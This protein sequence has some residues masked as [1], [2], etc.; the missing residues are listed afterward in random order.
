M[1]SLVNVK[2]SVSHSGQPI[3]AS[4]TVATPWTTSTSRASMERSSSICS[5]PCR[6]S[7]EIISATLDSSMASAYGCGMTQL[8]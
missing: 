3:D 8:G 2:Q 1:S 5:S 6:I 4:A 7:A